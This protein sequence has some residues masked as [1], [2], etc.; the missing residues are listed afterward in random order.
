MAVE[1]GKDDADSPAPLPY[2]FADTADEAHGLTRWNQPP[3][4]DHE[5]DARPMSPFPYAL[6]R[7]LNNLIAAGVWPGP[8]GPS[9]AAQQLAPR[10]SREHS[11]MFAEDETLICLER[12]PFRTIADAVRQAGSQGD[13]WQR[14]GALHQ[15][16]PDQAL[17]IGDFGM[18]SDSPIVLHF[19]EN[20]ADPPILRLRWGT[21]GE[22]NAWIQG[23]PNFDAFA[24][25]IG[26]VT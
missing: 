16:A 2:R 13:F 24:R 8:D 17:I 21:R 9:M 7:L 4:S 12:P 19:R 15:I 26:L 18:G 10:V 14:F 20:A 1:Y 25:L 23:A 11:R 5:T 3:A 6:P 22:R